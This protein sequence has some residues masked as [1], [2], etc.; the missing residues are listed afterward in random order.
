MSK[1]LTASAIVD[2][3]H[4]CLLAAWSVLYI[5]F[6]SWIVVSGHFWKTVLSSPLF[7]LDYIKYYSFAR[8]VTS[9]DS[10][11]LYDPHV[12]FKWVEQVVSPAHYDKIF[13]SEYPPFQGVLMA[14]ITWLRLDVGY[15]V[16][17]AILLTIGL[18][19]LLWSGKSL[20]R[21]PMTTA[22]AIV[23]GTFASVPGYWATLEGQLSW[24]MLGLF[25]LF[26]WAL[27]KRRD[28]A[29]GLLLAVT[30]LKPQFTVFLLPAALAGRRWKLILVAGIAE[31][32]LTVVSA[33]AAGWWNAIMFPVVAWKVQTAP[34]FMGVR[35]LVEEVENAVGLKRLLIM[36]FP[37]DVAFT[38][39]A[40][41]VPLALIILWLIWRKAWTVGDQSLPWAM[42]LTALTCLICSPYNHLY[43]CVLLGLPA[44]LTLPSVS[45]LAVSR[46]PS[47]ELRIWSALLILSP[48]LSWLVFVMPVHGIKPGPLFALCMNLLLAAAGS[49]VFARSI[50]PAGKKLDLL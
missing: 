11:A 10:L 43:D 25:G 31:A 35:M 14:P 49:Y 26:Y 7:F 38:I 1:R 2:N 12:Q 48:V 30:T 45:L 33:L 29:G 5:G 8:I 22:C 37:R 19:A 9:A 50:G 40:L 44:L 21:P 32:V 36:V 47:A 17:V 46:L 18:G 24:L 6:L 27:V 4:L 23:L 39:G 42:S 3:G 16:W 13:F 15:L 20:G 41:L 28:V 34:T